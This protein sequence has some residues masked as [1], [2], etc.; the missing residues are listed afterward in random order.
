[1][2]KARRQVRRESNSLLVRVEQRLRPATQSICLYM[3]RNTASHDEQR[4]ANEQLR[5]HIDLPMAAMR[6]M[7]KAKAN[8]SNE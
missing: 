5:E 6:L 4:Q 7:L 1:M 8:R 3:A 2:A